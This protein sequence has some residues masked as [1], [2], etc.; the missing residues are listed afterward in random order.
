MQN[1]KPCCPAAAARILKKL[2]LADGSQ[3]GIL[4][5]EEILKEVADLKLV[6]NETI[7]KELLK[8]VK[9]YNYVAPGADNEYSEALFNDYTRQYGKG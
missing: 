4:Y 3:A 6:D 1:E 9:I 5:L 2:T 7:R 8:R